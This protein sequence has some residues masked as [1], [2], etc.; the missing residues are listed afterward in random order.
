MSAA[1][2]VCGLGLWTPGFA[3]LAAWR[4]GAEDPSVT[5]PVGALM[6]KAT[7]RRATA[8]TRMAA[9][10]LAQALH[11][12]GIASD[13]TALVLGTVGGELD[14]T[15]A[16]LALTHEVPPASSP[17]RFR[18]SVHNAALGHVSIATGNRGY[19]SA[20]SA[21]ADRIVAMS[22]LEG[23][24]WAAT[25][26]GHVAVL[27]VDETWPT[28]RFDPVAGAVLLSAEPPPEAHV[29]GWLGAP[30]RELP[31]CQAP[32]WQRPSLA[33]NPSA[34]IVD[35]LTL[36]ADGAPGVLPLSPATDG[37]AP[38]SVPFTVARP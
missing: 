19:G 13:R 10:A 28:D 12:T 24:L 35:L 14:T 18:N 16:C 20:L 17:L 23:W 8:L 37:Q 9:D 25:Q 6:P 33:G 22:L 36:L 5:E 29:L 27:V 38:W 15:F 30:G 26:G 21:S 32:P 1:V 34:G 7:L 3:S 4:A 31:T 2:A 11:G